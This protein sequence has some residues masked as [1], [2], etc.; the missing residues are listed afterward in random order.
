MPATLHTHSDAF[1]KRPCL[2]ALTRDGL[3]HKY[4][5]NRL[6]ER[7]DIAAILVDTR[8]YKTT[9]RG[10][11]RPGVRSLLS[12]AALKVYWRAIGDRQSRVR[13]LKHMLGTRRTTEWIAQ[14]QRII[15]IDGI[16][17]DRAIE[18]VR[19]LTPDALLIY[20]TSIVKAPMLALA[21]NL[22]LNMHT[23]LSPHYRGTHCAF[24]PIVNGEP[25]MLGATVHECTADVD[26][27]QIFETATAC[28]Q[29][30]D[31]IHECFA[32]AV[33]AG[34]DAYVRVIERYLAGTLTGSK[35]DL[36]IGREYR[37]HMRTL[38]AELRARRALRKG[39]ENTSRPQ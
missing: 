34:A 10:A 16:N 33:V 29:P 8:E 24:W 36:S 5:M 20:G 21:R 14:S 23:G 1:L 17:S 30:G 38:G 12:R 13:S 6:C 27:G 19:G 32:R 4:V 35:Q 18:T 11:L 28:P 3:E 2:V 22:A 25:H 37:G 15:T 31:G 26:G 39:L 9:L 7:F